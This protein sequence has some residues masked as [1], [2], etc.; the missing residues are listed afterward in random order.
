MPPDRETLA[1]I[2]EYTGGESFNAESADEAKKVYT[3]LGSR[4][5]REDR[6]REVTAVFVAVGALLVAG[7]AG[8]A[9]PARLAFPE[10]ITPEAR[11]GSRAELMLL[12]SLHLTGLRWA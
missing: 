4:V 9:L 10:R 8:L 11:V 6:P 1:A 3:G 7:T 2:A 12:P 5:G